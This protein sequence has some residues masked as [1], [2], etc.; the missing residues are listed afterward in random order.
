MMA[1]RGRDHC[2]D[3]HASAIFQLGED[4]ITDAVQA[5]IEL[6]K[7]SY[8]ADADYAN[9]EV[10]TGRPNDV[11]D[12]FYAGAV[13]TIIVEDNGVGMD[14]DTI[15]R[16]WLTISNSLK[17][18]MKKAKQTSKRVRTPL[19]DKGLGRLGVQRLGYNVEIFTKPKG[20]SVEY[21]VGWS[22]KDFEDEHTL[23]D[24]QVQ[25]ESSPSNR[26]SGTR[27]VIS[28][29]RDSDYWNTQ[30]T[31]EEFEQRLSQLV[32]PYRHFQE[33]K[34]LASINGKELEPAEITERNRKLAQLR[35]KINFDG[36]KLVLR[37]RAALSFIR[38]DDKE[39]KHAFEQLV[40]ADDGEAFFAFL[41]EQKEAETFKL[42]RLTGDSWF[43]AAKREIPFAEIPG[44]RWIDEELSKADV[45]ARSVPKQNGS[46]GAV[47]KVPASPGPFYAEVDS[48]DLGRSAAE[49]AARS[50]FSSPA[51][52]RKIIKAL[53]GVRIYRDG[54]GVRVDNDWMGLAKQWTTA[55][56][57]YSLK[58]ENT[59]GYVAITAEH[60]QSLMETTDREGFKVTPQYENFLLLFSEFKSFAHDVQEFLRRHWTDF[61]KA[62]QR[63]LALVKE[64]ETPEEL[65]GQLESGLARASKLKGPLAKVKEGIAQATDAAA[66]ALH[67]SEG[68]ASSKELRELRA[69]V[70]TLGK[71][72]NNADK[73]LA[74]VTEFIDE[75]NHLRD[76][77]VVIQNDTQALRDQ[78]E[79]TY[80]VVSLGLTAEALSHEIE[81]VADQIVKR[82]QDISRHCKRVGVDDAR[83]LG[84]VDYIRSSVSALRKQ[85]AHLAPS[86]KYVREQR[87]SI[88]LDG[89]LESVNEYFRLR[90]KDEPIKLH[91]K[92][93]ESLS[94][95][96]NRGKLTQIIDNLILNSEYWLREDLQ[97]GR[98]EEGIITIL[99]SSPYVFCSDNGPGIDPIVENTLFDPFV[100]RKPK[101]KGRGLGLFIVREL[102]ETEGCSIALTQ[103]RNERGRLYRFQID[104]SGAINDSE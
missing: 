74:S 25:F 2:F 85:L 37:G 23:G 21:H 88:P 36:E 45:Y 17:R 31:L 71:Q 62:H 47:K 48:F 46:N 9:I 39:G 54:F 72:L 14:E 97:S 70:N 78:M 94:L 28:D 53:S 44:L 13:G 18:E 19:G 65:A 12:S 40:D 80:E 33:F 34:I 42:R 75:A 6:V 59:M 51:E 91:V 76:V 5:L 50:A 100:S 86:L 57:Y 95:L 92:S 58:P 7:N 38:P 43:A 64:G 87:E 103:R 11:A 69:T 24:V 77:S 60:N 27:I 84:Y 52:Y 89:F 3:I 82:T 10:L 49:S 35:Y 104:F 99:L 96:I 90:W 16:G 83:I 79:E 4:L 63:E 102:L 15:D 93:R 41:L 26:R 67:H 1:K 8:D 32:S 98:I 55:S 29:M 61:R 101:R 66:A 22:W 56:S 30:T 68:A 20:E 73:L 81:N